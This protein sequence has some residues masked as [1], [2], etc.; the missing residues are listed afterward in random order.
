MKLRRHVTSTLRR[1]RFFAT[2]REFATAKEFA[3][4]LRK[5]ELVRIHQWGI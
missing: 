5:D 3:D 1:T 4:A 2:G